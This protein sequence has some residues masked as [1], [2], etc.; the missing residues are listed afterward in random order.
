MTIAIVVAA[1]VVAA[2]GSGCATVRTTVTPFELAREAR[3]LVRDGRAEVAGLQGT[4]RVSADEV[5]QIRVRDGQLERPARVTV[6]ELVAGCV[7][8]LHAPGC[9]ATQIE[10]APVIERRRVRFSRE[11]AATAITI[12]LVG[13]TVGA[14]FALCEGDSDLGKG[15][16]I[17]GGVIAA[18]GLLFL[19]LMASSSR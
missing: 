3:P 11:R 17:T 5:V 14:C 9:L 18:G 13:S 19:L 4:V 16:A 12:G 15:A 8:D 1:A 10:D 7:D 6:R 2:V